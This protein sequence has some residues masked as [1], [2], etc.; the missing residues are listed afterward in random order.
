MDLTLRVREGGRTR[1][2]RVLLGGLLLTEE[3][4]VQR[5]LSFAP[6][7]PFNPE[8]IQEA[9]RRLAELGIFERVQVGSPSPPSGPFT[10]VDV[11]VREGKPW[12]LDLGGG[13][14]TDQEWRGFLE[15]GHDNLFGTGQSATAR[16][17]V[18]T[19][20]DR[21][22]LAYRSRRL[23]DTAWQA[24]ATLY[25]ERWEEIGYRRQTA[26]GTAGIQRTL[27][28]DLLRGLRGLLSYRLD[29]VRRFDV[30][31]SL[32][33]ADVQPGTQLLASLTPALALD[34][35]ND[36]RDPTAGSSHLL[37]LEVGAPVFGSEVH[38]VKF[39]AETRWFLDWR[40]P[41]VL[42]ISGR[43]GLA[44]PYG[45][46]PA[47]DI[48]DRFKAGG[49]TT[50][51]GYPE[52]RV[53]PADA[54]GNP[55]GGNGRVILNAEWRFPLWRWLG[56]VLFVDSGVVAPEAADIRLA[57]F[58]TGVG[59]GLRVKTPVGPLRV[60][61]GYALNTLPTRED[62]WQVYFSIGHSF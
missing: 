32:A 56:G 6:G 18:A 1:I 61:A 35:R 39:E 25:R 12:R 60:D 34:R 59:G 19:K 50:V 17:T 40:A 48:D 49:S 15:V 38:F 43:L 41:G 8:R 11:T 21:T 44:T 37:S 58:K 10:D 9:E 28:P 4:V 22:D 20:G 52:D 45:G 7:D 26:G 3:H 16:E 57:D 27:F 54:S 29:W 24:E 5:E 53:G 42:A 30:D 13:Y 55:V 33:A 36:P 23:F 47:L 14:S 2:G 62:R 51:R 46:T 31:P